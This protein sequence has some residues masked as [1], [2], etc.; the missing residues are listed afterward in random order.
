MV[1]EIKAVEYELLKTTAKRAGKKIIRG[2]KYRRDMK[3]L[4]KA[5]MSTD[6]YESLEPSPKQIR[7]WDPE[8][9]PPAKS[10]GPPHNSQ[11]AREA[12]GIFPL[13]RIMGFSTRHLTGQER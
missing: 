3:S 8:A 1:L 5:K 10:R 12:L 11:P 2:K 13:S 7:G 6:K 9:A 4:E